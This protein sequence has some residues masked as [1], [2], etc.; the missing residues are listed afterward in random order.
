MKKRFLRGTDH[1]DL[2]GGGARRLNGDC[3]LPKA[4]DFGAELLPLEE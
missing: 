3:S 2:T 1:L 4:R